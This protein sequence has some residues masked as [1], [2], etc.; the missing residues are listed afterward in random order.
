MQS[1][2]GVLNDRSA[3]IEP[4]LSAADLLLRER[5]AALP[6]QSPPGDGWHAIRAH[7]QARPASTNAPNRTPWWMALAAVLA[8]VSM[9]PAMR[10]SAELLPAAPAEVSALMQRSQALESEIRGLRANSA[11][12]AE[13]QYQWESAIEDDLALLDVGLTARSSAPQLWRERVRLLEEL[14]TAT[15]MDS[16]PLLLQARLD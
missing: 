10:Q 16:G 6:L 14:K 8:V 7:L 3:P 1:R 9:V 11:D 15:Q 4:P 5:L 13:V 12:V 2:T